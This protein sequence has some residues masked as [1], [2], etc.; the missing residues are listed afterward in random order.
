MLPVRS[1]TPV[2]RLDPGS[3]SIADVAFGDLDVSSLLEVGDRRAQHRV[4]GFEQL[5][6][7]RKSISVLRPSI[8]T[9]S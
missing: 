5:S 1:V 4:V 9:P 2:C 8:R 3:R 6:Q 7:V